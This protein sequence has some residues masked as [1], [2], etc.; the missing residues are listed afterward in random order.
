MN[1]LKI[2]D[3]RCKNHIS[4]MMCVHFLILVL[5]GF[6]CSKQKVIKTRARTCDENPSHTMITNINCMPNN[7][8]GIT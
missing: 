6:C 8:P 1:E 4:N 2:C 5:L 7:L 3:N